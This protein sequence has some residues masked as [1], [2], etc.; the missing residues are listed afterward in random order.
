[1]T[2][3][4]AV[5]VTLPEQWKLDLMPGGEVVI[6]ARDSETVFRAVMGNRHVR[7]QRRM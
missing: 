4:E 5:P 3:T 7:E 1:M 2:T 6:E